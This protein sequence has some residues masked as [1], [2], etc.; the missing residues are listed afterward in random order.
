MIHKLR[1]GLGMPSTKVH[2]ALQG[3][4]LKEGL[5]RVGRTNDMLPPREDDKVAGRIA[6]RFVAALEQSIHDH[7]YEPSRASFVYV[8]KTR[9]ATRPAALLTLADRVVYEAL[10]E[11]MRAKI[12][13]FLVSDSTVLWPRGATTEKRWNDFEVAPL[14]AGGGYVVIADVAGFYESIDHQ[15]LRQTLVKSGVGFSDAE[16]L[17]ELL[18]GVMGTGRGIPQGIATSDALATL[19]LAAADATV[20][21]TV[22]GYWR[23]GDD[24]RMTAVNFSEARR[25]VTVLEAALRESGL[26]MNAAKLRVLTFSTYAA[27]QADTERTRDEF[28]K[29]LLAARREAIKNSEEP[30]VLEELMKEA[31]LDEDMQWGFW[32]H[33]FI[34]IDVVLDALKDHIAP[35][36][37]EVQ[38]EMFRDAMQHRPGTPAGL[39]QELWHARLVYCLRRF[40]GAKS[41]AAL[42]HAG[43]LLVRN[44]E[45]TQSVASYL[46][47]LVDTQPEA[48]A[49]SVDHALENTH[50]LL[51][52]QRGWLYRVLSRVSAHVQPPI[53]DE[54][55]RV[56]QSQDED[57][58][59][60]IEAARLLA[61][62]GR[63]NGAY[64][65]SLLSNAPEA[66]HSDVIAIAAGLEATET[67]PKAFLDGV[68]QDPLGA[69]VVDGV[70]DKQ[71]TPK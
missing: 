45:E 25:A 18:H 40:A 15:R 36:V 50:F 41:E 21:R 57:W 34:E 53:L 29:R 33:G 43:E 19:Y 11:P 14:E 7:E 42:P 66:Y 9:F 68:R 35:S 24:L 58:L 59:A 13:K 48:V 61:A 12:E 70:R 46:L 20:R 44:P 26:L 28:G 63:F 55:E 65:N 64:S 67:W 56:M 4:S 23:H 6:A 69:V 27:N 30:E 39:S 31:G 54:A 5:S 47:S 16:A 37:L 71:R 49:R 8:P 60:R 17:E 51:G 2:T 52:W 38:R 32:Y 1:L 10:V 22:A 62:A 3:V